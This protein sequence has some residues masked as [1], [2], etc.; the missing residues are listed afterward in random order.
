[1]SRLTVVIASGKL[2]RIGQRSRSKRCAFVKRQGK[3]PGERMA[4]QNLY[5]SE[6][7]VEAKYWEKSN[8][9]TTLHEINQEFESPRIQLRQ[10]NR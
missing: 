4:Q 7:E 1:M 10:A 8:S 6:A 2:V 9:D 3:S 5:E